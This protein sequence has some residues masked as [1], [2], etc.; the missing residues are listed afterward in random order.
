MQNNQKTT[1]ANP[2]HVCNGT[3]IIMET[4]IPCPHHPQTTKSTIDVI[5]R[6]IR[7]HGVLYVDLNN[8]TSIALTIYHA[9]RNA[10]LVKRGS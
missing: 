10:G 6:A 5:D 4:N 2:C 1:Q 3:G 7:D 8:S 9:L